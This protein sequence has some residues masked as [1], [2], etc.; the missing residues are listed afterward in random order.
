ME[1]GRPRALTYRGEVYFPIVHYTVNVSFVVPRQPTVF[2][3]ALL[4]VI[5]LAETDASV[6]S[7][8]MEDVFQGILGV[9][10]ADAVILPVLT[11][12]F[13]QGVVRSNVPLESLARLR[14]GDLSLTPEAR[15]M[16][17][18]GRLPARG[19]E[20]SDELYYDPVLE[21]LERRVRTVDPGHAARIPFDHTTVGFPETLYRR[22]LLERNPGWL[23]PDAEITGVSVAGSTPTWVRA[24]AT[25]GIERG[26]LRIEFD[27]AERTRYVASLPSEVL[28][29]HI[30]DPLVADP[31]EELASLGLDTVDLRSEWRRYEQVEPT[32]LR[33]CLRRL[34]TDPNVL[35]CH[36]ALL[37]MVRGDSARVTIAFGSDARAPEVRAVDRARRWAIYLPEGLV[38]ADWVAGTL[39]GVVRA[40]RGI[41]RL[42]PGSTELVLGYQDESDDAREEVRR[43]L[44]NVAISLIGQ[45]IPGG[46]V[47][48]LC[49]TPDEFWEV[50]S[51]PGIWGECE[52]QEAL[53]DFVRLVNDLEGVDTRYLKGR[54]EDAVIGIVTGLKDRV[55]VNNVEELVS[56]IAGLR[57]RANLNIDRILAFIVE[58]VHVTS[59]DELGRLKTALR[60]LRADWRPTYRSNIYS[61]HLLRTLCND[62]FG[63]STQACLDGSNRFEET[64]QKWLSAVEQVHQS[65]NSVPVTE[66]LDDRRA[67]EQV[68]RLRLQK[69]WVDAVHQ[70]VAAWAELVGADAAFAAVARGTLAEV[71]A[72]NMARLAE[73]VRLA[74]ARSASCTVA[75]DTSALME[76]P[77]IL[78]DAASGRLV[79][80]LT[81]LE[82]LDRLKH[83]PDKHEAAQRAIRAIERFRDR[84]HFAQSEPPEGDADM[85]DSPDNRILRAVLNLA[86]S[87]PILVTED[88]NLRLKA[89]ARGITACDVAEARRLLRGLKR[90]QQERGNPA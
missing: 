54:V 17:E 6:A 75:F 57:T 83:R 88:R 27:A 58:R 12:L 87:N 40:F 15:R 52:F 71:I 2:E 55:H 85:P 80:P 50:L 51:V 42:G 14:C 64:F 78:G 41:V 73:M 13:N 53:W 47:V 22:W 5:R 21:R 18:E 16:L 10:H 4:R 69:A 19:Q 20:R 36:A 26:E 66:P 32:L 43:V 56:C 31:G 63:K 45:R 81:V 33:D 65:M 25:Y 90:S 76:D 23:P 30:V 48:A 59:P 86:D 29:E 84:I 24:T 8:A 68:R 46:A 1:V 89:G 72:N 44:H 74:H 49:F 70:A 77:G 3:E 39:A 61:E 28:R 38:G 62:P 35:L 79:I 7:L 9:P 37:P 67:F 11:G 34:S 60:T 82:E